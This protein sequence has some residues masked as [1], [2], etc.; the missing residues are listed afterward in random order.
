MSRAWAVVAIAALTTCTAADAGPRRVDLPTPGDHHYGIYLNRAK[1]GWMRTRVAV[2]KRVRF[3]TDLTATV[4]GMGTVSKVE[5]TEMR[6][7]DARSGVLEELLF[8]QSAA[9]GKVQ[10]RGER[11]G[12]VLELT[13]DAG[14]ATSKQTVKVTDTLEDATSVERLVSNAQVGATA[15][16]HRL[17]R[18][19]T[20]NC[21]NRRVTFNDEHR[22]VAG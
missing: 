7:Y 8:T 21:V 4:G 5:L 15:T 3:D 13:I 16:I 9:T 19:V 17:Q 11:R 22:E 6:A 20:V 18:P 12:K 14:G 10:V 2:G 1:V